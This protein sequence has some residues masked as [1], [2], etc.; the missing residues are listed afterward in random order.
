MTGQIW[1]SYDFPAHVFF[2]S[3]YQR[4]WWSLWEPRWFDGFDVSSYPPLS[5]QLAALLGWLIGIGN[6]VNILTATSVIILPIPV[7]RL[8]RRYFGVEAAGRAA[9]LAVV[10][11]SVLLAAYAFGQLP[12]VF[13]LD[14]SLFAAD[15]LGSFLRDGGV[16]RLSLLLTLGGVTV[17][18]H[19]ATF[20]FFLPPLLGTVALVELLAGRRRRQVAV[21]IVVAAA[22]LAAMAAMVILPFWVWHATDYVTQVPIDHQSR[23]DLLQDIVAQDLFFWG[24]HGVLVATLLLALPL[25]VR[26]LRQTLPWYALGVLLF[27]LGSGGTTPLPRILFG[28]QWA[29]LTYDRFSIW[30]DVPLIML[31]GAVAARCLDREGGGRTI[32]HA[33]WLVTLGLLGFYALT[34]VMMPAL[35]Q[36]EPKPIDPG[37]IVTYLRQNGDAQWRYITLGMGEQEGILNALADAGTVDGYYY[38]ARRL[39]LLTRSGIAQL[40]FSFL[41]DPRATTLSQLLADPAP[42]SLRW[43]FTKDPA[44]EQLL[45]RARWRERT[46]LSNGVRVW[47]SGDTVPPVG[48]PP[49][50]TGLLAVWWGIVPIAVVVSVGPA[51]WWVWRTREACIA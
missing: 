47:E 36:T 46:V 42:Y 37:P 29:W 39:P 14:A 32:A 11:P 28:S 13:A 21:R 45:E 8:S 51:G 49:L 6:A 23:H 33:A 16:P 50:K 30:A 40:D 12:T 44:Y 9:A 17:A 5:H 3:H 48:P 4:A 19:H 43:V 35:I 20:I 2:A 38:T 27:V 7:F 26:R 10:T 1:H 22:G 24:E 25:L 31:L 15:A 41:W 18:A 34:D